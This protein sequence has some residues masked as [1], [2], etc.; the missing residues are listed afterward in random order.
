NNY[1]ASRK[2]VTVL[3]A[4]HRAAASCQH[5][6][7]FL[8]QIFKYRFFTLTEAFFTFYIKNPRDVCTSAFF[9]HCI[10]VNKLHMQLLC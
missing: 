1:T 4:F 9:N 7:L 3:F 5:D 8:S 2:T 6:A 10:G